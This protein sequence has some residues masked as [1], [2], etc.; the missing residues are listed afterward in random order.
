MLARLARGRVYHAREQV[1][2]TVYVSL[3]GVSYELMVACSWY[4]RRL[5]ENRSKEEAESDY[6]HGVHVQHIQSKA[7]VVLHSHRNNTL[8]E[9]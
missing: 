7:G 3:C 1:K 5:G 9:T 2:Y 6:V 8:P 4:G